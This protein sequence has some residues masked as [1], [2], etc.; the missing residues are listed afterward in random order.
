VF[1]EHFFWEDNL[2]FI[3][4]PSLQ[5]ILSLNLVMKNP[6]FSFWFNTSGYQDMV[7]VFYL[8]HFGVFCLIQNCPLF[9][10]LQE[11]VKFLLVFV[12]VIEVI[13]C[14]SC[15]LSVYISVLPE[16]NNKFEQFWKLKTNYWKILQGSYRGNLG[17]ESLY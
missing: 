8:I 2:L 15:H 16:T 12:V 7:R 13:C 6:N 9:L 5:F 4:I 10:N 17:K 1:L 11:P 3:C 14:F